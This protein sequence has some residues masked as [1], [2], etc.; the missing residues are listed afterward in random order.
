MAAQLREI[1]KSEDIVVVP[2]AYDGVSGRAVLNKKKFKVMYMTGAGTV[3][4]M[5][6]IPDLGIAGLTDMHQNAAMLASLDPSVPLIADADTGYGGPLSCAR[7]LRLYHQAGVA[8]LHVEDQ[9]LGNKRCG[10]L[11]NKRVVSLETYITRVRAMVEER[12]RIG[13]EIVIIA[14]TD[15]LQMYGID[16]AIHRA[17]AAVEVGAD[18]VFV[19]GI[20]TEQEARKVVKELFP[21]PCLVNLIANSDTPSWT[22]EQVKEFGFKI[23]LFPLVTVVASVLAAEKALDFLNL[24]GSDFASSE[25]VSPKGFFAKMGLDEMTTFDNNVG[26]VF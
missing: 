18:A 1:L 26:G 23:A 2:G 20:T 6:G 19:E 14:R 9:E 21:V 11:K 12:K 7:T 10:H 5:M 4:S 16:E 13:S 22:V 3:A 24:S 15:A 8:G 17:K 25:G